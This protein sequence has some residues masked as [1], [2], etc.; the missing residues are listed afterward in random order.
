[1]HHN[2]LNR[3]LFEHEPF[4]YYAS[5]SS[6]PNWFCQRRISRS[7]CWLLPQYFFKKNFSY[8]AYIQ[9]LKVRPI[10]HSVWKST[11]K[12]S[13]YNI[14][15]YTFVIKE[16]YLKFPAKKQHFK[17]Q[18]WQSEN[19]NTIWKI[20]TIQTRLLFWFENSNGTLSVIFR[21]CVIF[22]LLWVLL[23]SIIRRICLMHTRTCNEKNL[24][25]FYS[26][27]HFECNCCCCAVKVCVF[28]DKNK[29]EIGLQNNKLSFFVV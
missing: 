19:W 14:M 8:N 17:I 1:M 26:A 6:H 7:S 5:S 21:H 2:N 27:T 12:V 25:W 23:L 4:F 3:H 20:M 28:L 29:T 24:A 9:Y 11:P 16:N 10:S 22:F 15:S 13:F 18:F